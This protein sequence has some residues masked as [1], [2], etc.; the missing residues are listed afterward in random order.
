MEDQKK[1]ARAVVELFG[2][3]AP[4]DGTRV[5][6]REG[7]FAVLRPVPPEFAKRL[8]RRYAAALTGKKATDNQRIEAGEALT[9]EHAVY[10]LVRLDR[11]DGYAFVT[12]SKEIAAAL[13]EALGADVQPG[14]EVNLD[15]KWNDAV[16]DVIFRHS[17]KF[18]KW[19]SDEAEKL[20][21]QEAEDEED[22]AGN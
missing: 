9:R 11:E 19:C 14:I 6:W 4:S 7:I 17:P 16:R 22:A 20:T 21:R 3:D 13:S 10:A 1:G 2:E 18:A 8:R 5:H 12:R 15:G